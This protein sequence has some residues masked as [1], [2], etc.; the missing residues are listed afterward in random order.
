MV[1]CC[2]LFLIPFCLSKFYPKTKFVSWLPGPPGKYALFLIKALSSEN[3]FHLFTHGYT[4]TILVSQGL[5]KNKDFFLIPPGVSDDFEIST[6]PRD[7]DT[8]LIRGLTVARLVPIKDIEFLIT[9]LF[10][11]KQNG[12]SFNW[13]IVGEGPLFQRIKLMIQSLGLSEEINLVGYKSHAEIQH[14]LHKTDVFALS[15]EFE[16]YSLAV[17]EAFS[18]GVPCL[19]RNVGYF[20]KLVGKSA[21]GANFDSPAEFYSALKSFLDQPAEY[22]KISMNCLQFASEHT[23]DRNAELFHEHVT[24]GHK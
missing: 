18:S 3:N 8:N 15:S 12:L 1:Y 11:C 7:I 5:I 13:I 24:S 16:N 22:R 19:L 6:A 10:Y 2:S 14:L 9:C 20:P 23:W 21:R 4:E 17:I